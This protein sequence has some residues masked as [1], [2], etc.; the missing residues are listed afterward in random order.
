MTA[1]QS[2]IELSMDNRQMHYS[3]AT[4]TLVPHAGTVKSPVHADSHVFLLSTYIFE[5]VKKPLLYVTYPP[6]S[7]LSN[8]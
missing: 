5:K 4:K 8:N 2:L 1:V 7:N 6:P 3:C